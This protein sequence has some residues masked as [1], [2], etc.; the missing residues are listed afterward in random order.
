MKLKKPDLEFAFSIEIEFP[1]EE[2][3]RFQPGCKDFTRGFVA[4]AGGTI[5]GPLLNGRV[6]SGSGGDWPRIWKSGLIEFEAHY[7]LEADDGTAIYIHNKG[8]A[9][10]S[11]ESLKKIEQGQQPAEPPYC[12]TTPR[13]DAP[14]G[15]HNWLNHKV[16]VG[17]CERRGD[18]SVFDYYIVS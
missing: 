16:L 13:F 15:P 4:V 2:R 7:M 17:T 14:E 1:P 18:K 5:E 9:F 3:L 12:R 11:P 8:I 6:V 10:A